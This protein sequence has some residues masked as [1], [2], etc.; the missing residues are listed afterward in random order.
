M[1]KKIK[2]EKKG[3][4]DGSIVFRPIS[5]PDQPTLIEKLREAIKKNY[6]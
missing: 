4:K 5:K 3:K 1:G 2:Y 6:S